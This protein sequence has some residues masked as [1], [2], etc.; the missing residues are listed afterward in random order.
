MKKRL[1]LFDHYSN[2][3]VYNKELLLPDIP[4][5]LS[6]AGH[7]VLCGY[8]KE[9]NLLR[10]DTGEAKTLFAVETDMKPLARSLGQN[11]LCILDDCMLYTI[12]LFVVNLQQLSHIS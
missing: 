6:W 9:Y 12:W 8:R 3:W 10:D 11:D 5:S 7:A 2:D 1:L 4:V